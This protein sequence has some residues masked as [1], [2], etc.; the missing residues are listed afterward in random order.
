MNL[1][2]YNSSGQKQTAYDVSADIFNLPKTNHNLLK[3]AYEH[4]LSQKRVNLAKVKTRSLVRGGGKKPHPQK[5]T[6]RA[7]AGSIRSPLWRGGG[8]I[9]GPT[10]QENY[11][12][13]LNKKAKSLALK[14]ALTLKNKNILSLKSLPEDGKTATLNK[15]LFQTLKLDRKILIV[16]FKTPESSRLAIRNLRDVSFIDVSYL[17]VFRILNADWLVFTADAL[18]NLQ[19]KVSSLNVKSIK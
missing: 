15:L 14:Q 5:G 3:A 4:Y 10:G 11:A 1:P 16:G 17:N 12:K 19:E 7:R 18:E 8:V 9:F 6:G 2:H 13:K